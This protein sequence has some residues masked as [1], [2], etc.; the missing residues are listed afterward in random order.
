MA[1]PV[2]PPFDAHRRVVGTD[3]LLTLT[4]ALVCCGVRALTIGGRG[5]AGDLAGGAAARVSG[6][7]GVTPGQTLYIEVG[8]DGQNA[9]P[10][11]GGGG[12]NGA[13]A[14]SG[15]LGS[16]GEGASDVRTAPRA[17]GLSP[18]SGLSVAAGGGGTGEA[19]R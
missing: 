7:L 16:G 9:E 8:G 11:V 5:G 10:S 14:A 17:A 12:F 3:A 13:G 19:V 1:A 4:L 18:D 15:R 6:H 2:Q